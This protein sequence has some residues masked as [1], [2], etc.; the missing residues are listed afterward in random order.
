MEQN[1]SV[2][3]KTYVVKELKYKDIAALGQIKNSEAAKQMLQLSS[4]I[5][6]EEYDNLSMSDGLELMKIVSCP[7]FLSVL[8]TCTPHQS[9]S[10]ELP[11]Q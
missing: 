10:T 1:V 7:S 4:G 6:D 9:N 3:D 11:I 8:K 5:T 2:G